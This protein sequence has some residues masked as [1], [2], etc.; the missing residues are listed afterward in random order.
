MKCYSFKFQVAGINRSAKTYEDA[1]YEAGCDDALVIVL[2]GQ[3]FLDFDREAPS[4]EAAVRSA[5]SDVEKVG[6]HVIEVE[7]LPS[8]V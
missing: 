7:R 1:L 2:D 4:Y 5:K 8:G 6:G 3:V